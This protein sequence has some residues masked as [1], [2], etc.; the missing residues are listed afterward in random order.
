MIGELKNKWSNMS[1]LECQVLEGL[2]LV[3][4]SARLLSTV[5]TVTEVDDRTS[6]RSDVF[7]LDRN[8]A[9]A[10]ARLD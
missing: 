1:G 5:R 4:L 3:N 8:Q 10:A 6:P 2:P 9:W 7:T